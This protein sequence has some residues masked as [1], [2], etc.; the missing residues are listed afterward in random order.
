MRFVFM[1]IATL[2]LVKKVIE[3]ANKKDKGEEK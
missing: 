1:S 2:I 3:W